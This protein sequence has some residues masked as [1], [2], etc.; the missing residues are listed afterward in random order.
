MD[1]FRGL[2]GSIMSASGTQSQTTSLYLKDISL[3]LT[4]VSSAREFNLGMHLTA[5]REFLNLV[6]AIMS[7]MPVNSYQHV[8][9]RN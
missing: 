2:K 1:K 4:L 6:H 9:L 8:V 3:M 5:E 7:T